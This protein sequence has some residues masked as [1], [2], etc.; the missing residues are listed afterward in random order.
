MCGMALTC[1]SCSTPYRGDDVN[2]ATGLAR[3][4]ICDR[5]DQLTATTASPAPAQVKPEAEL[6]RPTAIT[7]EARGGA[8]TLSYR[9]YHPTV[10]FM[11]PFCIAWDSFL[12]FWYAMALG[13]GAESGGDGPIWLMIIFPIAHVAVGVG[14]TWHTIAT[15][16]NTTRFSIANGRFTVSHGPIPWFGGLDVREDVVRQLYVVESNVR[17]NKQTTYKVCALIEG[18][19]KE[20][21]SGIAELSVARYL[22]ARLERQLGLADAVVTGEVR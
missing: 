9:W 14:L 15:L 12:V 10:W 20:L 19:A 22:E 3:C 5:V 11:V 16:F 1:P 17:R 4:R 2:L 21:V 7:E 13:I 6:A 18:T 8:F